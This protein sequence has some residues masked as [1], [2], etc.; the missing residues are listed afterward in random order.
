M[1]VHTGTSSYM[2][3][4]YG[5]E[6]SQCLGHKAGLFLQLVCEC[7]FGFSFLFFGGGKGE[8]HIQA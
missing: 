3:Q 1:D 8:G 2:K 6:E 7:F 5:E 4:I